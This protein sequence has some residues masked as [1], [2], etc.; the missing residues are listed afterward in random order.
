MTL[1][2]ISIP[3]RA[4]EVDHIDDEAGLVAR[5]ARHDPGALRT[6]MRR[7]NRRLFRI[8]RS[9]LRNDS[10]AEDAVQSAYLHAFRGL[11]E[12]R[13]ASALGTWLS[14]IVINEA[15][16]LARGRKPAL[17]A[18][19]DGEALLAGQVIPFPHAAASP[20]PER[21]MAQRQIQAAIERAI[22]DLPEAF[23][24]V[25]VARVMEEMSVEETAELLGIRTET[26]K[27]R[28]HR[29]RH[30]LR[31]ALEKQIGPVLL[32]AFP[33]GGRRC[34]RMTDA[35]MRILGVADPREPLP[36]TSIE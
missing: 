1:G 28:L 35:V 21:A 33:F 24:M 17:H 16:G 7:Y 27:T 31:R 3:T 5:A 6:I 20:D 8:A 11:A 9:I 4:V 13:G 22:D 18:T 12:F 36:A 14:R 32:D 19:A 2:E 25:L 30:L 34:E 23:R 15:L 26:V 29:A 10:E